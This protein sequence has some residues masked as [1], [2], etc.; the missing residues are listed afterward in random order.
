M[1]NTLEFV[2]DTLEKLRTESL[3]SLDGREQQMV[4]KRNRVR[5][6]L[7]HIMEVQHDV[8]GQ[9]FVLTGQKTYTYRDRIK[10]A[11]PE[12]T[13]NREKKGW[14]IPCDNQ[15]IDGI[16][17]RVEQWETNDALIKQELRVEDKRRKRAIKLERQRSEQ[18]AQSD[19][20]KQRIKYWQAVCPDIDQW[21]DMY[22]RDNGIHQHP[23]C[24]RC[25]WLAPQ[26]AVPWTSSL[27]VE[28]TP[29]EEG[30]SPATEEDKVVNTHHTSMMITACPWCM[31]SF[32]D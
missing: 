8:D 18:F 2:R 6:T 21:L 23:S 22:C 13:W 1:N 17:S 4:P 12:A 3:P 9:C 28:H 7:A 24:Q 16:R 26:F 27:P 5:V 30:M 10:S 31:R 19:E 20:C 11:F 25:V 32:V 15:T 14:C 29:P